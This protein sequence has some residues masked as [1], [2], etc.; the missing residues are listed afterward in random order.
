[1]CHFSLVWFSDYF[2]NLLNAFLS[3]DLPFCLWVVQSTFWIQTLYPIVFR[4]A[5]SLS[6][7]HTHKHTKSVMSLILGL[8][9]SLYAFVSAHREEMYMVLGNSTLDWNI[10][11]MLLKGRIQPIRYIFLELLEVSVAMGFK[12]YLV[13][14]SGK[15]HWIK[16]LYETSCQQINM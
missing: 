15:C 13:A 3:G 11:T 10:L 9:T 5:C 16:W 6:L 4:C 8:Y 7:F 1:M 14:L 2:I 12:N